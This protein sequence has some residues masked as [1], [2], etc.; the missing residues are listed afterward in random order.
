MIRKTPPPEPEG[1][2]GAR[3]GAQTGFGDE[4]CELV[5]TFAGEDLGFGINAGL[6]GIEAGRG[7][8]LNGARAGGFLG[9]L[10]V[11]LGLFER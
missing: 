8:A 10:M 1:S 7:L 6:Q 9:V 4:D 3:R 11:R 5:R 2:E